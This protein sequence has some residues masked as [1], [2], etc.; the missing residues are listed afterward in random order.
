MLVVCVVGTMVIWLTQALRLLELVVE[1]G[2]PISMLLYMMM[3]SVP[4]FLSLVLPL[5]LTVGVLFV[6]HKLLMDSELVVL[7]AT[8]QSYWRITK[9]ILVLSLFTAAAGLFVTLILAPFAN[10][11]LAREEFLAKND[12]ALVLLRDGSFNRLNDGVTAYV[13]DRVGGEEIQGLLLH[14]E[15]KPD[16]S[17][18]LIAQKGLLVDTAQGKRLV[19]VNGV[20]QERERASGRINELRFDQYTL[21]LSQFGTSLETR[22]QKPREMSTLALFD[23]RVFTEKAVFWTKQAAELHGRLATPFLA[24]GFATVVTALLLTATVNRRGMLGRLMIAAGVVILWQVAVI[25]SINFIP[26]N[27]ALACILY[28]MVFLPLPYLLFVVK[29]GY[30]GIGNRSVT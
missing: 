7:Q 10:S 25:A 16:K 29:R 21:D 2:A 17:E 12:Y 15:S 18:T 13:R 20:R 6:M 14:D 8:G 26:K 1:R 3:L 4:A 24:I 27:P 5:G 28:A 19:L 30:W 23:K 22:N 9:P 11:M